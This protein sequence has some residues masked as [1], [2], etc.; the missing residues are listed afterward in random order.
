MVKI[1][2]QAVI[3]SK[4]DK[5]EKKKNKGTRRTLEDETFIPKGSVASSSTGPKETQMHIENF[6]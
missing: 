6:P 4:C 2:R 3:I 1:V 5:Q